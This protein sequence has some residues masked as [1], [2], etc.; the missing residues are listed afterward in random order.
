MSYK[1]TAKK[2]AGYRRQ[3]AALR[4]RMR[5]A[6]A[7][8]SPEEVQDYEL[9]T[10]KGSVRLSALFGDKDD[11]IVI[12]NMGTSCPYCML[13]ADGYNGV[14]HHLADR[15]A[16]VVASPDTPAVQQ[17]FAS[18]RG[19]RFPMVSHK[20]TSFAEDMGYRSKNGWLPGISVFKREK[21][22]ILRVSDAPF[23]PGDDFCALWHIL[24]LF[25]EGAAAW[26]PK[27]RYG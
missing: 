26:S 12:H 3:I 23:S 4:Q 14:Y 18:G 11:L 16:F 10:P 22:R 27:F 6:Q 9:A 8:V 19:W 15:A 2:L 7:A 25:P 1:D 5:K 13:W 21:G 20:G 17:K 24:D